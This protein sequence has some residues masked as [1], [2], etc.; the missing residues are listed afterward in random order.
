MYGNENPE[1]DV[2][3]QL[4]ESGVYLYLCETCII[5]RERSMLHALLYGVVFVVCHIVCHTGMSCRLQLLGS[6]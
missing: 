6:I 1:D 4:L 3:P 2:Q 5:G